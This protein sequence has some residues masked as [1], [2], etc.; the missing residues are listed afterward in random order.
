MLSLPL[1]D[2]NIDLEGIGTI[3][4][5][6]TANI[7]FDVRDPRSDLIREK[8]VLNPSEFVEQDESSREPPHHFALT[9]E[10]QKKKSVIAVL[11]EAAVKSTMKKSEKKKKGGGGGGVAEVGIPRDVAA[12]DSGEFVPILAMDCRGIEPY[13]FHPMGEELIV[14][15]EGGAV[16]RSDLTLDE[17]DWADYDEENDISVSI[18]EFESKFVSAA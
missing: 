11:D 8:V 12:D 3:S 6:R 10:G 17:G 13:A 4:L 18:S 1:R 2:Q 5:D 7:C 9:W 14:T 15:S 16:F